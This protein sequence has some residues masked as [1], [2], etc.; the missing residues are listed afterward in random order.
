M[1]L[2]MPAPALEVRLL[3]GFAV[4]ADGQDVPLPTHAQRVLA[5]LGLNEQQV[6]LRRL[7]LAE[8]LWPG[9]PTARAQAS[10][11]TALWRVRQ[12]DPRLVRVVQDEVSL[13]PDVTVDLH[14]T[15]DR[16]RRLLDGA[17]V[18][19]VDPLAVDS[20]RRDL[21]PGWDED[22]LVLERERVRQVQIHALE[23]LSRRLCNQGRHAE[24]IDTALAAIALEPMRE[25]SH[26]A[27]I[28]AYVADGN[29]AAA[30]RQAARLTALLDRELSVAPSRAFLAEFHRLVDAL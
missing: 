30:V 27:L 14:G 12:G 6:A 26:A 18:T 17:D 25:A 24:A 9:A 15:L 2:V 28:A 5:F 13:G 1:S 29:A 7:P 8:V 10:L 21:L 22:W 4:I 23:V 3:G 20:L 16:G 19:A 11:R